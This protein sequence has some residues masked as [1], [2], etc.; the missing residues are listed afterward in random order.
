MSKALSSPTASSSSCVPPSPT[1]II[2]CRRRC[3]SKPP[4]RSTSFAATF[5]L[6]Q[7]IVRRSRRPALGLHGARVTAPVPLDADAEILAG[8]FPRVLWA[9]EHVNQEGGIDRAA[10]SSLQLVQWHSRSVLAAFPAKRDEVFHKGSSSPA[11]LRW[12]RWQLGVHKKRAGGL[13][14]LD[15]QASCGSCSPTAYR[16][17]AAASRTPELSSLHV[18]HSRASRSQRSG[19]GRQI[20]EIM[21]KAGPPTIEE[22]ADFGRHRA[23]HSRDCTRDPSCERGAGPLWGGAFGRVFLRSRS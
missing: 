19:S 12:P 22:G 7:I 3:L 15:R 11:P 1:P 10:R 14:D 5:S 2:A 13:D 9:F 8:C 18:R 16:P 20:E 6:A 23:V 21:D 4:A 17:R